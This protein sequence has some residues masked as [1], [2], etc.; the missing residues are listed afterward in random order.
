MHLALRLFLLAFT[1]TACR[2][3]RPG[4]DTPVRPIEEIGPSFDAATALHI[5]AGTRLPVRLKLDVPFVE[6]QGVDSVALTFTRD[7]YWW[8]RNPGWISFDGKD[9]RRVHDFFAGELAVSVGRRTDRDPE[10]TISV[11]LK[12]RGS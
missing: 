1:L 7:V 9:W 2:T 10:A 4:S 5:P 11:T 12:P 8:P 6:T 3:P